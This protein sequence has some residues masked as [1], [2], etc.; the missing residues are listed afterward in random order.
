L[1]DPVGYTSTGTGTLQFENGPVRRYQ[2]LPN[3]VSFVPQGVMARSNR[4][5]TVQFIQIRETP[6]AYDAFI[7]ELVRGGAVDLEPT[8]PFDDPLVSQI[9]SAIANEMKGGFLDRIPVDALNTGLA[10]QIT[11]RFVDPSAIAPTPSSGLSRERLNRVQDY[12]EA[13]LDDRL[14]LADLAG[15]ACLSPHHLSRSFKQ[16]TGVG[17]Q[18]YV[19]Q[20]RLERAKTLIRQG[21]QPLALIAQEVGFTDQSHLTSIFRRETGV[22]PG[23]Y[24]AALA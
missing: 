19:M 18:R 23:R 16:A 2:Y 17:P 8:M 5:I 7:S 21:N 4:P 9:M 12:V 10:V 20:R 6:E 22:T 11:R 3:Q 15:V 13:H 1:Y 14:S 24:R